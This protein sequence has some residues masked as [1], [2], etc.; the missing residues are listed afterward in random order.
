MRWTKGK[1]EEKE[2]ER[3]EN[4]GRIMK[5]FILILSTPRESRVKNTIEINVIK[6]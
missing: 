2:R 6:L 1:R 5:S 4:T 3:V